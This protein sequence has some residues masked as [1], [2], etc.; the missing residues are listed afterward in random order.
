[1]NFVYNKDSYLITLGKKYIMSRSTVNRSNTPTMLKVFD[2]IEKFMPS[3]QVNALKQNMLGEEG[4]FFVDLA[5]D[6]DETIRTMPKTYDCKDSSNPQVHLH[7]FFRGC[8]W[9]IIEKD[10]EGKRTEQA[11][12]FAILHE[13]TDNAELGYISIDELLSVDG[14]QMD[15]YFKKVDLNTIKRE[16]GIRVRN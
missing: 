14:V 11:F 13:D 3:Y 8:D 9:Y 12:G 16:K 1:M 10:K 15:F 2:N 5:K 6:I 4:S 7:Y